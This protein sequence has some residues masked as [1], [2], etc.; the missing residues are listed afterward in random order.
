MNTKN[1]DE[2]R[3]YKDR[4]PLTRKEI[5]MRKRATDKKFDS[6]PSMRR[7]LN[8]IKV[9]AESG[10]DKNALERVTDE[11]QNSA[12]YAVD[13]IERMKREATDLFNDE[14]QAHETYHH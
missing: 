2:Q 14:P 11:W 6:V 10:Y 1:N 7:H 13:E 4:L 9:L 5:M 12:K 3:P 8:A